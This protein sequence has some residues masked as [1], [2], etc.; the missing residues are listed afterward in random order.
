MWW[1]T[2]QCGNS[3]RLSHELCVRA[4]LPS[5]VISVDRNR[6]RLRCNKTSPSGGSTSAGRRSEGNPWNLSVLRVICVTIEQSYNRGCTIARWLRRSL[7]K[8]KGSTGSLQTV[9]L[10]RL[11]RPMAR[12]CYILTDYDCG[13]RLSLE[14]GAVRERRARERGEWSCHT[15][16]WST[17]PGQGLRNF[18]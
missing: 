2:A 4:R 16:Q 1:T 17:T 15:E 5:Q 10:R 3:T 14:K 11:I 7:L 6:S 12:S 9:C 13:Q 18:S 8:R